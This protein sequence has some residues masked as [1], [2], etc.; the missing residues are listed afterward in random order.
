M[1]DD[2]Q[3]IHS[4]FRQEEPRQ[5]Y[6]GRCWDHCVL[7]DWHL[8]LDQELAVLR[9]LS[10]VG[11]ASGNYAVDVQHRIPSLGSRDM[12]QQEGQDLEE[13]AAAAV[14]VVAPKIG[15]VDAVQSMGAELARQPVD[16]LKETH[17]DDVAAGAPSRKVLREVEEDMVLEGSRIVHWDEDEDGDEEDEEELSEED[18]VG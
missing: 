16:V 5:R 1:R 4:G 6:Y 14:E 17:L 2:I 3:M 10:E 9:P 18:P 11:L 7:V 12:I 8:S 13:A 15:F